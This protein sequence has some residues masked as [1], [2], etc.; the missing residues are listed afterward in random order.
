MRDSQRCWWGFAKRQTRAPRF[1]SAGRT[2]R[3]FPSPLASC[4]GGS[5]RATFLPRT[6]GFLKRRLPF[7]GTELHR[8]GSEAISV[9]MLLLFCG[10]AKPKSSPLSQFAWRPPSKRNLPRLFCMDLKFQVCNPL[11]SE[12]PRDNMPT[13]NCFLQL[14]VARVLGARRHLFL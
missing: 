13:I 1:P 2:L 14:C 7:Q 3:L 8:R 4:F 9:M 6:S 10:D 11:L 12:E 5:Y